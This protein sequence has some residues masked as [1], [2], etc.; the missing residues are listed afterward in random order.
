MASDGNRLPL[1]C[2]FCKQVTVRLATHLRRECNKNATDD[3]I[4]IQTDEARSNARRILTNLSK[5][6]Y[7]DLEAGMKSTQSLAFM[8]KLL[9]S[10]GVTIVDKPLETARSQMQEEA[11]DV[12]PE[13][14][15]GARTVCTFKDNELGKH[16]EYSVLLVEFRRYLEQHYSKTSSIHDL[17]NV[18]RFLHFMDSQ[19]VSVSV[20]HNH[21]KIVEFFDRISRFSST[22]QR[23]YFHSVKKFITYV[24]A[25]EKLIAED[26]SL[27]GSVERC[28]KCLSKIQK[29]SGKTAPEEQKRKAV[30]PEDC[31]EALR[32]ARPYFLENIDTAN[33]GLTLDERDRI[34]VLH[35]LE[36]V[37]VVGHLHR[38]S[39]IQDMTVRHW[40][41]RK[42]CTCQEE[43]DS[44]R[45]AVIKVDAG[46]SQKTIV[47][48]ETEEMWLDTF[49][50]KIRPHF[51]KKGKGSECFF[52][53]SK[54]DK[55]SNPSAHIGRFQQR[56][57]ACSSTGQEA[58][59]IFTEVILTSCQ[60]EDQDIL[61]NYLQSNMKSAEGKMLEFL[62]A[63]LLV[64]KLQFTWTS[65]S[66]SQD[67]QSD[68]FD[69]YDMEPECAPINEREM[70]YKI[71]F[72]NFPVGLDNRGPTLKDTQKISDMHGKYCYDRWRRQQYKQRRD[73]IIAQ[74]KTNKPTLHQVTNYIQRQGWQSNIPSG[75]D[76]FQYW[77][78]KHHRG[79][80]DINAQ[81]MELIK[82]QMWPGLSIVSD[83]VKGEKLVTQTPIKKGDFVCDYHG[84]IILAKRGED[85]MSARSEE[86]SGYFFFFKDRENK[87]VCM[88]LK[89]SPALATQK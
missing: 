55:V 32:I 84:P 81:L 6:N 3:E 26:P 76:I 2:T 43:G 57:N 31:V 9:E 71:L 58:R 78:P 14:D 22:T 74:F 70:A 42:H 37:L 24:A 7:K 82:S 75:Y 72:E 56:F 17:N 35:F 36:C 44:I 62:H 12:D 86:E 54:G 30:N 67:T 38:P 25:E 27:R 73:D 85:M 40:L 79:K 52:L 87:R 59:A 80:V 8:T 1:L 29:N 34:A 18:S 63:A 83:R 10:S 49:F 21:E 23:N 64:P 46:D 11:S 16:S 53:S 13:V 47:L 41:E 60:K 50:M 66:A 28:F 77:E 45:V 19:Q 5:V 15:Q 39:I 68:L 20:L 69:Y 61:Y 4:K 65:S 48:S 89:M 88:M 33:S 51:L